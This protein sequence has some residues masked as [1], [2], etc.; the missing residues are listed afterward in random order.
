MDAV[1]EQGGYKRVALLLSVGDADALEQVIESGISTKAL[2]RR[3]D[4]QIKK[5]TCVRLV[6]FFKPGKCCVFFSQACVHSR[7]R[8]ASRITWSP[9]R[10]NLLQDL[11]GCVLPAG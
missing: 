10:F 9:C 7:N 8:I 1:R 11:T 5:R 6:R 3:M 2:K 4:L